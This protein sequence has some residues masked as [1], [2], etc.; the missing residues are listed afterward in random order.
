MQKTK[1]DNVDHQTKTTTS[2]ESGWRSHD[3]C[4]NNIK[5]NNV[6]G[7]LILSENWHHTF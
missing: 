2:Q 6:D 7:L 3:I 1:H 4:Q 5:L